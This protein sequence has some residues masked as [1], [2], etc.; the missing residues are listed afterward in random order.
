M[1]AWGET[2]EEAEGRPRSEANPV[3]RSASHLQRAAGQRQEGAAQ[4]AARQPRQRGQPRRRRHRLQPPPRRR[5]LR[6]APQRPQPARR[7]ARATHL[8]TRQRQ[9][10]AAGQR[11]RQPAEPRPS[12][13]SRNT[14]RQGPRARGCKRRVGGLGAGLRGPC[15]A[16][17]RA[18]DGSVRVVL[19]GGN[20][21]AGGAAGRARRARDAPPS[22]RKGQRGVVVGLL[23]LPAGEGTRQSSPPSSPA[24]PCLAQTWDG[25]VAMCVLQRPE[26]AAR[27]RGQHV[28]SFPAPRRR[29]PRRPS[30][31]A[32]LRCRSGPRPRRPRRPPPGRCRHPGPLQP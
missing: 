26:A 32:R 18:V 12:P 13:S 4:P 3:W 31:S 15:A 14:R 28:L 27:L 9:R 7:K 5:Q 8:A 21:A 17:E 24:L 2:G 19:A 16:K 20:A 29:T 1:H 23:I 30:R 25:C 10:G 22:A 6:H 11:E